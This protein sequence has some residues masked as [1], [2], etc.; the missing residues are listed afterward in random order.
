MRLV[1]KC[2]IFFFYEISLFINFYLNDRLKV[3]CYYWLLEV[4]L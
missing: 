4:V 3:S 1:L 2:N